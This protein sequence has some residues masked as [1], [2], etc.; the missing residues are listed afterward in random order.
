V[1]DVD[2]AQSLGATGVL[3]RS[4]KFREQDLERGSPDHVI[5]SIADLTHLLGA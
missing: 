3:V 2:A 1:T 4:G 5:E